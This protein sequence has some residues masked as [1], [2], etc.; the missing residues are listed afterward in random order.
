MSS[1][2]DELNDGLDQ[3][4]E[5]ADFVRAGRDSITALS[6]SQVLTEK[7]GNP[8]QHCIEFD[9]VHKHCGDMACSF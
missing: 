1:T 4:F 3:Y 8:L 5:L 9:T 2:D 7:N 6:V